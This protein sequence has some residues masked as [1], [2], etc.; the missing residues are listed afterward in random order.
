MRHLILQR[1]QVRFLTLTWWLTSITPVP[2][3]LNLL[4]NSTGFYMHVVHIHTGTHA[5][6][7]I[8]TY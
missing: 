5:H 7:H 3:H 2:K 8:N 4:L 6:T 1:L